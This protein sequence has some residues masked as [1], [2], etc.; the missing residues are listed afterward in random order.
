MACFASADKDSGANYIATGITR[1]AVHPS[2]FTHAGEDMSPDG[3]LC[4]ATGGAPWVDPCATATSATRNLET[5]RE[6]SHYEI[7]HLI[8]VSCDLATRS[9]R[10]FG[11]QGNLKAGAVP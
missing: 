8:E 6:R 4:P 10:N 1:D 9:E 11:G 2:A 3:V 7:L 5:R